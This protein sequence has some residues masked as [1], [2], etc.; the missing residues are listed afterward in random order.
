MNDFGQVNFSEPLP[1]RLVDYVRRTDSLA[2]YREFLTT[3]W[4]SPSEIREM[5]WRE[6]KRLIDHVYHQVPYY[7]KLFVSMG[8]H[9]DDITSEE[10]YRTLPLLNKDHIRAHYPDMLAQN[11]AL[12]QP[13]KKATGGSTGQPLQYYLD[14]KSH[15]ALWAFI[16]RSWNIG[17]WNPGDKVVVIGGSSLVPSIATLKKYLYVKLNNWLFL[18]AFGINDA[19]VRKWIPKLRKFRAKFMYAYASSAYLL[20]QYLEKQGVDDVGFEAVFTTSEVLYPKYRD[21]IS[22]VFS[23]EVF[24]TYGGTDGAGYAFECERHEGLHI[25]AENSYMEVVS[26]EGTSV[27]YGGTGEIITTDL[28]NYAMPFLR[29]R[30][31]DM[32]TLEGEPCSC[33]RGLPRLKKILGRSPDFI[34]AR[35][36]R[37]FHEEFFAYLFRD[38][39]WLSQ[40]YVIQHSYEKLEVY[41]KPN[42]LP[43]TPELKKV[44]DSLKRTF[45]GMDIVIQ[46]TDK[47]PVRS[48]GKYKYI[49]NKISLPAGSWGEG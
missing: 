1:L 12:F 23:S 26:N 28:Y 10:A 36:G 3:Q 31:G 43:R 35:D 17:G 16:Y 13:R 11:R 30:T 40:Y 45:R 29:Y 25:V 38:I 9:P 48:S 19:T 5:Q 46:M 27:K 33:G 8:V 42:C 4:L 15:G 7:H 44:Y 39:Q 41:L 18:S 6:L 49:V 47:M 21:T 20:A 37:R 32:A 24:D 2:L 34:I 22:R 14:R